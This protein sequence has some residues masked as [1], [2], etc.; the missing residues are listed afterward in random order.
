MTTARF[1][2]CEDCPEMIDLDGVHVELEDDKGEFYLHAQCF[3]DGGWM[4]DD[5]IVGQG[6]AEAALRMN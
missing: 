1:V 4:R 3:L 6:V 5:D 2:P